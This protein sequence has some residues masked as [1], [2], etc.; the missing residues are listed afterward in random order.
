MHCA[1]NQLSLWYFFY[2]TLLNRMLS[3]YLGEYLST[4][5]QV[6]NCC[7]LAHQNKEYGGSIRLLQRVTKQSIMLHTPHSLPCGE[8]WRVFHNH[9]AAH[10][11]LVMVVSEEKL[12]CSEV[13]QCTRG[14]KIWDSAGHRGALMNYTGWEILVHINLWRVHQVSHG[15][16]T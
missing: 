2:S 6:L 1:C 4:A 5:G 11:W 13:S 8:Q 3:C 9:R 15:T 14:D 10:D 16:L 12:C 7:P